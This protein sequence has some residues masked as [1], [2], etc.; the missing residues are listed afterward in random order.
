MSDINLGSPVREIRVFLS[1]TFRDMQEERNY[2]MANIFPLVRQRCHERDVVFTEIDL[3]WG[4]TEEAAQNGRT[5]ELCLQEIGRC[6]ALVLPPFFIGFLGERYGWVPALQDLGA[7]WNAHAGS[8]YAER[9]RQALSQGLSVT[10]LEIRFGFLDS[11]GSAAP[12]RVLMLLRDPA[13]TRHFTK[14]SLSQPLVESAATRVS[15]TTRLRRL[16]ASSP[17]PSDVSGTKEQSALSDE[18]GDAPASKYKLELL[19]EVVRKAHRVNSISL[20]DGYDSVAAFGHA[21]HDFLVEQIDALFPIQEAPD[22][23]TQVTAAHRAYAASRLRSYVDTPFLSEQMLA[24]LHSPDSKHLA[25]LQGTSGSGKSAFL[26]HL[27][28]RVGKCGDSWVFTHFCGVDGYAKLNHWRDR[29][30]DALRANGWGTASLSGQDAERWAELPLLLAQASRVTGRS[31]VLVLDAINQ[32]AE[33]PS[34]LDQLEITAWPA[35]VRL[36]ASCTPDVTVGPAWH[37]ENMPALCEAARREFVTSFLGNFAKS[38]SEPLMQEVVSAPACE[39]RLFLKLVLEEA[40][41]HASHESLPARV[42]DMLKHPGSGALFLACLE[43]V[44]RDFAIHASGLA[45]AASRLIGASRRGLTQHELAELLSALG[46]TRLPDAV[47]LPLLANLQPYLERHDGRLQLMH[48]TLADALQARHTAALAVR[49]QLIDYFNGDDPWALTERAYQLIRIESG[50]LEKRVQDMY[51]GKIE[52]SDAS[53]LSSEEMVAYLFKKDE[54]SNYRI[55]KSF[56]NLP[57]FVQIWALDSN[58]VVNALDMIGAGKPWQLTDYQIALVDGWFASIKSLRADALQNLQ[59]VRLGT[60]FVE[61]GFFFLA[62]SF[63]LRLMD[64]QRTLVPEDGES[65]AIVA[66]QLGNV[67][68]MANEFRHAEAILSLALTD[69]QRAEMAHN[70]KAIPTLTLLAGTLRRLDQKERALSVQER[71]MAIHMAPLNEFDRE[72]CTIAVVLAVLYAEC[73]YLD[74]ARSL[75]ESTLEA[76]RRLLGSTHREVALMLDA[77]SMICVHEQDFTVAE[78]F[79]RE[80]V[81]LLRA[82]TPGVEWALA[83]SLF[84]LGMLR[85][86][87][88]EADDAETIYEEAWASYQLLETRFDPNVLFVLSR[89]S[90]LKSARGDPEAALSSLQDLLRLCDTSDD[91]PHTNLLN[92]ARALEQK[93]LLLI[94]RGTKEQA[95]DCYSQAY[96]LLR[97]LPATEETIALMAKSRLGMGNATFAAS[98]DVAWGSKYV[99]RYHLVGTK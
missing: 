95:V 72:A 15:F 6:R 36:I 62:K 67:F 39:N 22:A 3:R 28:A 38:I 10:E 30:L 83:N 8:P 77:V 69:W 31:I 4:I 82:A 52:G 2:L 51:I 40:R 88:D 20:M 63:L 37:I 53:N 78:R 81:Q 23:T 60:W 44:D 55:V 19:K 9:I 66:T 35:G 46:R 27:A 65:C 16:L 7:Y 85:E 71:A 70:H 64:L 17:E 11:L 87:F 41:V 89:L 92:A 26:A 24:W 75:A 58:V 48:T 86:K 84:K 56:G 90:A 93:A 96:A 59:L 12:C 68:F 47:L 42:G 29:L 74:K 61:M 50:N 79:L 80:A 45:T 18:F 33:F 32:L 43:E 94:N 25:M 98:F 13:L 99:V 76:G 91:A 21:V 54:D 97:R 73:G 57:M 49:R 1:S 5:V 14:Q 34:A